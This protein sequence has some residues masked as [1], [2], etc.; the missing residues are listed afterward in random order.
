M[1][2]FDKVPDGPPALIRLHDLDQDAVRQKLLTELT[3][4]SGF[5]MDLPSSNASKGLERLRNALKAEQIT[6]T[7]DAA[8]AAKQRTPNYALLLED[9]TPEE[10]ARVFQHLGGEDKKAVAK[11]D[12]YF[13][14]LL[15]YRMG[16]KDHK[17][18]SNLLGVD[19][20]AAPPKP[21]SPMVDIRKPLA[22]GT[23][24][25]LKPRSEKGTRLALVLP[26]HPGK[27]RPAA[28]EVKHYLAT[29]KPARPGTL[30]VLLVLR[31]V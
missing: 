22:E 9:L 4:A 2:K 3:R 5:R 1:I 17:E 27:S 19:P 20:T 14:L 10:F 15:V 18:L 13:N 24:D 12:A 28:A 29:R 25:Q 6:M 26:Y 31:D 30:K 23:A 16:E 7:L 8:T 21:S 11:R